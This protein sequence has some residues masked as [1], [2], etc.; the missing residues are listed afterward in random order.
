MTIA[1]PWHV[2]LETARR[3]GLLL[4]EVLRTGVSPTKLDKA[5]TKLGIRFHPDVRELYGLA[6]GLRRIRGHN[7]EP[8]LRGFSFRGRQEAVRR[9]ISLRDAVEEYG[10]AGA[11]RASWLKVFDD[12]DN[13]NF[14]VD[15]LL[16]W[17]NADGVIEPKPELIPLPTRTDGRQFCA[18]YGMREGQP[19]EYGSPSR[20]CDQ[21]IAAAMP[22]K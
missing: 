9:T 6:D 8:S 1:E 16:T 18:S 11:W 5:E 12:I 19:D 17:I 13:E 14:M 20:T 10:T 7:N 3:R 2:V 22:V 4:D 21:A 15:I